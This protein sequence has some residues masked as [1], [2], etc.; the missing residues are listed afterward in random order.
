M[1]RRFFVLSLM[2]ASTFATQGV[3]QGEPKTP[4]DQMKVAAVLNGLADGTPPTFAKGELPISSEFTLSTPVQDLAIILNGILFH[5]TETNVHADAVTSWSGYL[6]RHIERNDF[7]DCPKQGDYSQL[8]VKYTNGTEELIPFL[9]DTD[10]N[11]EGLSKEYAYSIDQHRNYIRL[12]APA[13]KQIA[14]IVFVPAGWLSQYSGFLRVHLLRPGASGAKMIFQYCNSDRTHDGFNRVF[15]APVHCVGENSNYAGEFLVAVGGFESAT[16][17]LSTSRR[18]QAKAGKPVVLI[19]QGVFQYS[20]WNFNQ[21]LGKHAGGGPGYQDAAFRFDHE[22][23][24]T[25]IIPHDDV[26][27]IALGNDFHLKAFTSEGTPI[28]VRGLTQLK[29]PHQFRIE[30]NE[31]G[32]DGIVDLY[33]ED[34][35]AMMTWD[36]AGALIVQQ[37]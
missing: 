33:I 34:N 11:G 3:C 24:G 4:S 27:N 6:L 28:K 5:R 1:T 18:I 36:N 10:L 9:R 37:E 25:E 21:P 19:V 13:D 16:R 31:P 8:R 29:A 35:F 2:A 7:I 22:R 14:K 23:S 15:E 17:G 32:A 26:R 12:K 30:L 20:A